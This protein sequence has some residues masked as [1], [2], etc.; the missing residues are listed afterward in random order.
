MRTAKDMLKEA[1]NSEGELVELSN[2]DFEYLLKQKR[3]RLIAA[4]M[5]V[6]ETSAGLRV[7]D[8]YSHELDYMGLGFQTFTDGRFENQRWN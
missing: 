8:L 5:Y 2:E 6:P 7:F 3:A 1:R 4:D